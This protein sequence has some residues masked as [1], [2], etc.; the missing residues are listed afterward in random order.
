V[1]FAIEHLSPA[2]ALPFAAPHAP[3]ASTPHALDHVVVASDDLEAAR[4]LYAGALGL[5]LALDRRF[6]ARGLRIL[7]FR[8]AG[9]TLEI[10]G[11]LAPPPAPA[12]SDRF[13]GL[14]YRVAD[15]AAARARLLAEGFDVS[16]PR[17]GFKPGTR[18][19]SVRSGTHGVPTLLIGPTGPAT[20]ARERAIS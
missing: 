17:D 20:E 1:L 9:T 18:V 19:C 7:F 5:R 14:A 8:L 15:V 13:G 11:P 12:A 3:A 4:R 16:E 2:A 10:A 6:E